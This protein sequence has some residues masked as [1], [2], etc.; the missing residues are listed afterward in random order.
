MFVETWD[1]GF[2][3]MFRNSVQTH[4][5]ELPLIQLSKRAMT[6]GSTKKHKRVTYTH[7]GLSTQVLPVHLGGTG[8]KGYDG[9]QFIIGLPFLS[10][11]FRLC[12]CFLRKNKIIVFSSGR[13]N[14][15]AKYH[16]MNQRSTQSTM[17]C[18]FPAIKQKKLTLI[19][20]H[21]TVATGQI[22]RIQRLNVNWLAVILSAPGADFKYLKVTRP[23]P[24]YGRQGLDWDL[25]EC[26][27]NR[28]KPTSFDA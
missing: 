2:N 15:D 3:S 28:P 6:G 16:A 11:T 20:P 27:Q 22:L 14:M 9:I 18:R 4:R 13:H 23:K 25:C 10:R 21:R 7:S 19:S 1:S 12:E 17:R 8:N 26:T 5:Q 24:A